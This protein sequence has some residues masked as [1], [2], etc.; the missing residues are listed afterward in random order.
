MGLS[1][2]LNSPPGTCCLDW[3]TH[4]PVGGVLDREGL[5]SIEQWQRAW[6]CKSGGTVHRPIRSAWQV[7]LILPEHPLGQVLFWGCWAQ[8]L[9]LNQP[10]CLQIPSGEGALAMLEGF[11][12]GGA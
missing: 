9:C 8:P 6:V 2:S 3:P 5:G 7:G 1:G 4:G 10:L 11:S 12:D